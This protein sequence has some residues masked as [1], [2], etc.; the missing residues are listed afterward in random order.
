M[1]YTPRLEPFGYAPLEANLC[2][3]PVIGIAE[4]GVRETI[5]DGIN[6]FL[7]PTEDSERL[8]NIITQLMENVTETEELRRPVASTSSIPGQSTKQLSVWNNDLLQ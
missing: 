5:I 8:G 2:G 7:T 4:G 6:G 1:I 3:L